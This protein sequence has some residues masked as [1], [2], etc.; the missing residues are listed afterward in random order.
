M[1]RFN[2]DYRLTGINGNSFETS[3][4]VDANDEEH[5]EGVFM[6]KEFAFREGDREWNEINEERIDSLN[7]L[8]IEEEVA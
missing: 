1:K 4:V 3:V 6:E 2:I 7:I 8:S 5:A